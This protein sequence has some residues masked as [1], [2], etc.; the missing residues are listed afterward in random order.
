MSNCPKCDF[1]T[2]PADPCICDFE[3]YRDRA[4]A[5]GT[6][7]RIDAGDW[8]L[9]DPLSGEWAD[10][11]TP[12]RLATALGVPAEAEDLPSYCDAFETGYTG[13]PV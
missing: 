7:A 2:T 9:T 13:Q 4:F 3:T 11:W 6:Q 1:P 5:F 10:S 8:P 12:Y